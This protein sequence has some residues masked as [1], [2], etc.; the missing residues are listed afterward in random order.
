MNRGEIWWASMPDP[1][2]SE[3]GYRHPIVIVSA[4][5][6]NKSNIQT[7]IVAIITSNLHLADAPGNFKLTKSKSGL[8]RDSAVNVSQIVTLDKT[9]LTEKV[10]RL[11][12]KQLNLLDVGL[13]L[14]LSV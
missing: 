10:G 12:T 6:F 4:N 11:S 8:N 3:P 2:A 13:Q 7:V 14:V 9:F 1:H 5:Y